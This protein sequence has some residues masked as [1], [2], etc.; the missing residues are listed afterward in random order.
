MASRERVKFISNLIYEET[1]GVHEI[2]ST[3]LIRDAVTYNKY[4]IKNSFTAMDV[5]YAVK[6]SGLTHHAFDG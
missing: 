2:L 3:N 4:A 5:A 6:S 1:R